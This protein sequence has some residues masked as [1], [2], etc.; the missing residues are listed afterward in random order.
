MHKTIV[1]L[2]PGVLTLLLCAGCAST[3]P[4]GRSVADVSQERDVGRALAASL[5]R[6]H[7]GL[8]RDE[9]LTRYLNLVGLSVAEFSGRPELP[10]H[11]GL[12]DSDE[13]LVF[14][15]PGGYVLI[16]RAAMLAMEDEAELAGVL[17]HEITHISLDHAGDFRAGNR[18][19][20]L[21]G[22]FLSGGGAVLNSAVRSNVQKLEEALLEEGRSPDLEFEADRGGVMLAAAAGYDPRGI[23]R[24]FERIGR[25]GDTERFAKTHPAMGERVT[26]LSEFLREQGLGGGENFAARFRD[27]RSRLSTIEKNTES[28]P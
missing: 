10:Y 24:Y 18:F 7:G 26:R 25:G 2:L 1:S 28:T 19:V 16:S 17:A 14:A 13:V 3:G 8:V 22:T 11:F 27:H 6:Q 12:L 20:A 5:I 23:V 9:P 21:L 15:C 4:S